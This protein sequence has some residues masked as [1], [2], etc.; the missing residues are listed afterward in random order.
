MWTERIALVEKANSA[1]PLAPGMM[2][3]LLSAEFKNRKP[4][5]WHQILATIEATRPQGV[6]A[7]A[8]ALQN[9]DFKQQLPSL[10][11]PTLVLCGQNDPATPPSEAK[12]IA[13]LIPHA[14]YIEIP[15]ALHFSN[16]EQA[17][18]YS[19]TLLDWFSKRY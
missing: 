19:K 6:Y 13:G 10:T 11:T 5:R 9:F 18:I 2:G 3:R 14:Q 7:C 8:Q 15:N 1:A 4:S 12:I 17:D 16:V